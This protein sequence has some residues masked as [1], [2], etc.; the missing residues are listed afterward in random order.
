L[1]ESLSK[2]HH[3]FETPCGSYAHMKLT[4]YLLRVT[5]DGRYG[6]SME[7]VMYNTVLGA[8]PLKADGSTFYYSDYNFKG[9]RI[10]HQSSWACCAGTLPQ[11]VAD[12]GI[13]SYF[14]E[15]GAVWVNLYISSVLRWSEGSN[16]LELAQT[17]T[18][19]LSSEVEFR[20]KASRPQD[21]ALYLRI[22]A[23]AEG[24]AIAVN[25]KGTP[26]EVRKGFA[27]VRRT[28][29]TGDVVELNLPSKLRLEPIDNAHPKVVALMQG[30]LV[31]FG[32]T[33]DQ[34]LITLNQALQARRSSAAEWVLDGNQE[35]VKLVPFTE[36]G[37]A[38]YTTYLQ[39]S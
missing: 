3:S 24:A 39:L 15:P 37:E 30:P 35:A 22:P 28:W 29:N 19:P 9:K 8:L 25:G 13:N 5:R 31:L 23:W 36:I 38:E 17:G 14:H 26:L 11:V 4:R 18:Y 1:F 33:K 16:Q 20:L 7:R 27:V 10:Y 34:P 21:F 12:Y 2:S 6:D 32:K